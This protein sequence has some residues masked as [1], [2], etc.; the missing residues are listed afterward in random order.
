MVRPI[1]DGV[2]GRRACTFVVMGPA[3][4]F[5]SL[6]GQL[7]V[8][9]N[10]QVDPGPTLWYGPTDKNIEG[11][12]DQKFN[13]LF[14]E[15]PPLQGLLYDDPSKHSKQKISFPFNVYL[16]ILTAGA[17]PNRQS[18][19]A[20]DIIMDEAWMYEPG[21][22][23]QIQLRRESYPND[24]RE[25]L[26]SNGF[27]AKTQ[28]ARIWENTDQG[29]WTVRCPSCRAWFEPRFLHKNDSGDILG[30]IRFAT[31]LR[32][33]GLPDEAAI[34][35]STHH[36]CPACRATLPDSPASRTALS[37]TA[38]QPVGEYVAKNLRPSP[39][40]QGWQVNGVAVRPWGKLA[41]KWVYAQLARERGDVRPI[42]QMVRL[43]FADLW[44]DNMYFTRSQNRPIGKYRM[45]EDWDGEMRD[46]QGLPW[47]LGTIDVQTDCY[48]LVIRMWGRFSRSRLRLAA[49]VMSVSDL[50]ILLQMNHVLPSRTFMDARFEPQRVRRIAAIKGWHTL[51]GDKDNRGGY[52]HADGIFRIYDEGKI[53]DPLIGTPEQG[54]GRRVLEILFSKQAALN[55]LHLLRTE[56]AIGP[57]DGEGRPIGDPEPLWTSAQDVPVGYWAQV[58]AHRR[59]KK[60]NPDGSEYTVW[61]GLKDDHWGD[62]EVEQVVGASIAGLTGAESLE[63]PAAAPL[64]EQPNG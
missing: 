58:E 47:R 10:L 3:Q 2:D 6:V 23:G 50:E 56:A 34:Q 14:E 39:G 7:L 15:C 24:Y 13:P 44:D 5:K 37:G 62:C 20:R 38:S 41:T 57:I 1:L 9:R 45:G 21:W 27:T 51:M 53:H 11:F 18:K 29:Q 32:D 35:A 61:E 40:H 26:L 36:E 64:T 17:D 46:A 16:Q 28:E 25:V 4:V 43:D 48:Y 8:L 52:R 60:T 19:T 31:V 55:R 49:K 12:V 59:K 33:D 54:T 30:G 63:P 22:T 42:E